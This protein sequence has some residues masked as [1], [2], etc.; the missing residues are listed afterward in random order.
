MKIFSVPKLR[1]LLEFLTLKRTEIEGIHPALFCSI[2]RLNLQFPA[3]FHVLLALL[4][5][6]YLD[7]A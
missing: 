6:R 7:H 5:I 2:I 4:F 1:E 3:P